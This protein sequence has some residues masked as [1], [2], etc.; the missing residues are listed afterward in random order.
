ME[1]Q[2]KVI[3]GHERLEVYQLSV[4]FVSS[5]FPVIEALPSKHSI[6]DQLNRASTSIALN[7][8]EG[9][10]RYTS[11]DKCRFFDIAKGS[12]LECAACIDILSQTNLIEEEL[13][14]NLKTILG[15][16]VQMIVGLIR[17]TSN[18]RTY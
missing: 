17:K 7:I 4:T 12:A 5:V 9:N 8:A 10:G 3:L 6:R 1:E 11:K 2:M 14:D 13:R 16:I 18:T 15:R